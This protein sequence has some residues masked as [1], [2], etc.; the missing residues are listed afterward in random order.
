LSSLSIAERDTWLLTLREATFG[1]ALEARVECPA[2][3]Q[4]LEFAARAADLRAMLHAAEAGPLEVTT[5]G[6]RWTVRLPDS[7]DLCAVAGCPDVD[8]ARKRLAAR[9]VTGLEGEPDALPEPV[10]AALAERAAGSEAV[11]DLHCPQCGHR[12]RSV[13][14]IVPFLWAEV[15]ARA[16]ALLRDV[17][18]LARAYGWSER[19]ILFM[20]P[21]RRR[22]YL[23]LAA[24]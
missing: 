18:A 16:R 1:P 24:T 15:G 23:E 7:G 6:G 20:S 14:D 8:T 12:W 11:L 2:C 9:C 19:D 3:G 21:W 4:S 17:A 22:Q 5:G 10:L 13:F